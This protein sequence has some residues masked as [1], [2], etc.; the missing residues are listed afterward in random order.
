MKQ[1]RK[2]YSTDFKA[3]VATEALRGEQARAIQSP[4]FGRQITFLGDTVQDTGR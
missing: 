4:D 3:K 1:T 2:R